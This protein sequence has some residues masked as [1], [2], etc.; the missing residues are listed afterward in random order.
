MMFVIPGL[1]R[2]KLPAVRAAPLLPFQEPS[3]LR[4]LPMFRQETFSMSVL[5][6][7]VPCRIK[8]IGIHLHLLMVSDLDLVTNV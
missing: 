4:P 5:E 7:G 8:W 6:V 1:H 2:Q 3:T